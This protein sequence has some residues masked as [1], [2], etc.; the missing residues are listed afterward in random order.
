MVNSAA[1]DENT[2][3]KSRGLNEPLS[4]RLMSS[5]PVFP[6]TREII[7]RKE[8]LVKPYSWKSDFALGFDLTGDATSS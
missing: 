5:L 1:I 2:S 8:V 7:I 3:M 6:A 4:A